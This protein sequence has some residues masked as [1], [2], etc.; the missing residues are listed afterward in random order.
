MPGG[1]HMGATLLA[2]AK[3]GAVTTA[4]ID[5]S[6]SRILTQVRVIFSGLYRECVLVLKTPSSLTHRMSRILAQMYKFGLFEHMSQWN[7]SAHQNDVTS[8]ANSQLAR[9]ISA[10]ATVLLTNNGL[11]PLKPGKKVAGS[12]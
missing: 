7:G 12:A 11:L 4:K 10:Q 3:S 6:V 8:M 9:N 1:G 2:A 5:D